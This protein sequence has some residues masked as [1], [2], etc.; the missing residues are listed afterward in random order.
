MNLLAKILRKHW[1]ISGEITDLGKKPSWYVNCT[2]YETGKRFR[3]TQGNMGDYQI[4]YVKNPKIPLADAVA[5][6][7][8]FPILIG[9]YKMRTDKYLWTKTYYSKNNPIHHHLK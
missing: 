8:G 2:T 6:S 4:G 9:P 3:F 7:A 1:G 5:S